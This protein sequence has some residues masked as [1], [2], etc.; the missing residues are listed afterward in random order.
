[1]QISDAGLDIIRIYEGLRLK[2]YLCPARVWTIGFGHTYQ[3]KK[4]DEITEAMAT[5]YLKKDVRHAQV[6]VDSHVKVPLEQN[7]F[8]ALVSLIFNIGAGAFKASTLSRML[9]KGNYAG[10]EDQFRRWNKARVDGVLK[11]LRGL[12][13]RRADEA[14]LFG[15]HQYAGIAQAVAAPSVKTKLNSKTNITA[16]GGGLGVLLSQGENLGG[17]VD[18]LKAIGAKGGDLADQMGAI[19]SADNAPLIA[20]AAVIGVFAYIIYER[21]KKV[22]EHGV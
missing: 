2:A 21:S 10:A 18:D 7:Q 8:D 19:F 16:V 13:R 22:D 6:T 5:E 20:M 15:S 4:G 3:V 9:N 11:P 12:T 14:N 17:I 1:M